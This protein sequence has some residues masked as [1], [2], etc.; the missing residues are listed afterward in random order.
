MNV[1]GR[2]P[3][4]ESNREGQPRDI[5]RFTAEQREYLDRHLRCQVCILSGYSLWE[6]IDHGLQVDIMGQPSRVPKN[7]RFP[8]KNLRSLRSEVAL[9]IEDPFFQGERGVS[10]E[11]QLRNYNGVLPNEAAGITAIIGSL[12]DYVELG[13]IL[14]STLQRSRSDIFTRGFI[15]TSDPLQRAD[16]RGWALRAVDYDMRSRGCIAKRMNIGGMSTTSLLAMMLYVPGGDA[17][18]KFVYLNE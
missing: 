9:N 6:L 18:Q 12:A 3:E 7:D 16:E 15:R 5:A 11:N 1:R 4:S 2:G 8:W 14:G 10:V 13:L 17:A